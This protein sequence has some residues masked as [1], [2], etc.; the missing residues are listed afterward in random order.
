MRFMDIMPSL[1]QREL[2]TTAGQRPLNIDHF[3]TKHERHVASLTCMN[4][5]VGSFIFLMK[6]EFCF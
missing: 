1:D 3:A 2:N 6:Y 4:N 5:G